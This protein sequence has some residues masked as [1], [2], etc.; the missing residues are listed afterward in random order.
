MAERSET[1][2]ERVVDGTTLYRLEAY[3]TD[4]VLKV[5]DVARFTWTASPGGP[6]VVPLP[7]VDLG[8]IDVLKHGL[9]RAVQAT[10]EGSAVLHGGAVDVDGAAVAVIGPSGTGKSTTTALLCAAGA[11]LLGDDVLILDLADGEVACRR[12]SDHVRL[13]SS[14]AE[15]APLVSAIPPAVTADGRIA[16]SPT[17]SLTERCPVRL[18]VLPRPTKDATAIEATRRPPA[19]AIFDLLGQ[20]RVDGLTRVEHQTALF[21]AA[22]A[23]CNQAPVVELT[24]PWGPPWSRQGADDLL[25]AVRRCLAEA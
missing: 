25:A 16:V 15:I 18:V 14:A 17:V 7:G 21:D 8:L 2:A 12:V 3:G 6:E 10:L 23:L 24:V 13:R 11:H 1:L 22:A 20:P 19:Q 5:E 9:V 4:I